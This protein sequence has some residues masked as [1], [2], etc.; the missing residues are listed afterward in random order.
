[1]WFLRH[2]GSHFLLFFCPF[3]GW[4]SYSFRICLTYKVLV[5]PHQHS[6]EVASWWLSW[7][8]H[9]FLCKFLLV[10]GSTKWDDFCLGP[11]RY[12]LESRMS[13]QVRESWLRLLLLAIFLCGLT[14][15][16][17]LKQ[18]R[19]GCVVIELF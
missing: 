5:W 11:Y 9:H 8:C 13:S 3:W 18:E 16:G 17:S 2:G 12:F 1:L 7:D 10:H 4:W 15:K 14:L 6:N 19:N